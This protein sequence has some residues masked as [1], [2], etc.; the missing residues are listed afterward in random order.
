[1]IITPAQCKALLQNN[2]LTDLSIN[3]YIPVVE[4]A[5]CD[6]CKDDFLDRSILNNGYYLNAYIQSSKLTFTQ[7]TNSVNDSDSK[8]D[9]YNFKVGDSVRTY[10]TRNNPNTFT[11]KSISASSIVFENL[12]EIADENFGRN[13]LIV[14][15]YY[16]KPLML[17]AAQMIKF[18][19]SKIDLA[20]KSEHIDDYTYTN[21]D[22][23]ID[24]YPLSIM[25][26]LN[27]YRN[28]YRKTLPMNWQLGG[29]YCD[30]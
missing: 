4:Q 12:N 10:F 30:C 3:T 27:N 9:T 21:Y 25:G 2:I 16:P 28:L 14:R 7:S 26:S 18:N 23:Y 19:L 29:M 11:I 15:V 6:Y 20:L 13:I 5:I 24:G 17:I 8:L 1:V 22:K